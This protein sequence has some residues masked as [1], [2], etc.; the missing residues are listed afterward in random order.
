MNLKL[1]HI[2]HVGLPVSNLEIS[3]AFYRKLGF[4]N[5]MASGFDYKGGRGSVA[6][7]RQG[8]I[9]LELYQLPEA[10]LEEIRKRTDGHVDHIAFDVDNIDEVFATLKGEAFTPVEGAP[11]FLPFWSKGCKYFNILGPDGERLEFNQILTDP[12]R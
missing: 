11:V 9:I 6:M 3:E 8:E 2:Q 4:A 1:N 10:Q 12:L 5:V 7:M